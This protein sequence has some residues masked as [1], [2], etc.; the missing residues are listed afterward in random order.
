VSWGSAEAPVPSAN[1]ELVGGDMAAKG[2]G[3]RIDW[4][5]LVDRERR[6]GRAL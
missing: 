3:M 1:V 5:E 2:R 6:V 4:P